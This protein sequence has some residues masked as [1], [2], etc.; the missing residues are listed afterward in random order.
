MSI[1]L[2]FGLAAFIIIVG[3]IISTLT[4]HHHWKK[5]RLPK[6]HKDAE[7]TATPVS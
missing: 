6:P 1:V 7:K 4:I 5:S 3:L 2:F